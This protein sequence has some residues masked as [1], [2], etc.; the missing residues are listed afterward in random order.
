MPVTPPTERIARLRQHVIDHGH[1]TNHEPTLYW[2]RS[3]QATAGEIWH[4]VRRARATAHILDNL[5]PVIDPDELLVGKFAP[6]CPTEEEQAELGSWATVERSL[7]V[8]TG[9]TA[10]QAVD[11]ERVLLYGVSGLKEL[12][13]GYRSELDLARADDLEKDAFYRA[14]LIALDGL[15]ALSRRYAELAIRMAETEADPARRAELLE[16]A[17][18]CRTVPEYPATTFREALQAAHLLTFALCAGQRMLLFQ[19]G[20]PDRY[21]LPFYRR[22]IAAGR[23]TPEQAQELLD[24]AAI[25]L[26][27]YTPKGLA[28][29]YMVGGRDSSGTDV[30]N[31]LTDM[32]LEGIAHVR[33]SYPGVGLCWT[34]E[35]PPHVMRLAGRLLAEGYTHPAIFQDDV[36]SAGLR[37]AGVSPADSRLYIH[38]TC[39][40]ITPIASSN[41][42]VASPYL[43]IVQLLHDS[44]GVPPLGGEAPEQTPLYA[45]FDALLGELRRRI[46]EAVRCAVVET[47]AAQLSRK[48]H[49]G[50]PLQSCF[51]N[52]CLARGLDIDHGGARHNW[53]EPVFVGTANV[54]DSLA[55]IRQFVFEDKSISL[56]ELAQVLA[57]DYEG[58][59]DLRAMMLNRA[60]KYGNDDDSVDALVAKLT[61]WYS[62]ECRKYR[63]ALGGTYQA[64]MFCWIQHG[65]L[66]RTTCASA[67][68]RRAGLA[69]A[70]GAGASQGRDSTGAT[71]AVLSA[72]KWDHRPMLGGIAVNVRF[73]PSA[74]KGALGELIRQVCHT[75]LQRGGA[76]IQV[77]VVDTETLREAKCHPENHRDLVVRIAGYSDYFVSLPDVLQDEV[78]ART[79]HEMA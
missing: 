31:E 23:I 51:V 77:N 49:G 27:E 34:P 24:C 7:P 39:V 75:Y 69:L 68:G 78:I 5:T 66:G 20:R 9:M 16:I 1:R 67:D 61:S 59:E 14:C 76:E 47:N 52:D 40:E 38:S 60:P 42:Y 3:W 50:A 41:V 2:A 43:N 57:S 62:E 8:V 56:T 12:I 10:H 26:S 30:C 37:A 4:I 35:T 11:I 36:I 32:L 55:A 13:E 65:E 25:L 79:A 18:V 15:V 33:L 54:A 72:T 29:G 28:V 58:R 45:S 63:S 74:D 19:L 22:D 21:L 53:I 71:A 48:R 64:G 46:G 44:I 73:S 17:T 70:D 6:V